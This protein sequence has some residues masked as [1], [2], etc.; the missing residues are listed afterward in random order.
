MKAETNYLR[1]KIEELELKIFSY[2]LRVEN[3]E[4]IEVNKSLIIG[5]EHNKKMINN[6]LEYINK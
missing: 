2:T 5:Y 6:I 3:N 4:D 1:S